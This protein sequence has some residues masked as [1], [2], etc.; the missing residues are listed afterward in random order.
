VSDTTTWWLTPVV[1]SSGMVTR[2]PRRRPDETDPP[3]RRI[4]EPSGPPEGAFEMAAAESGPVDIVLLKFEGNKFNGEIAPALRDLVVNGLVRVIDLLFVFKDAD[5]EVGSIELAGLGA[6]LDPVFADLDGQLG[7][8]LLDA[9]DVDE[10]GS[11]LEPNSSVAVLAVENLW[12]I[13]F[14]TAVRRAGGELI[15]QARVPSDVVAM[16]RDITS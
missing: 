10:V 6:D 16:V 1:S 8:G 11:V 4:G 7:G 2:D 9:E 14:V 13:P 12:A 15:D 5:G 3:T